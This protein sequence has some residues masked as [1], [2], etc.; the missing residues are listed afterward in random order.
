MQDPVAGKEVTQEVVFGD[1]SEK[2]GVKHYRKITALRDGKKLFE[3]VV[4]ELEFFDKLDDKVF[5]KP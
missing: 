2:D 3:G 4:T 1:Y 5:A